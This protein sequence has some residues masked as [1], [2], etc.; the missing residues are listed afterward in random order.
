MITVVQ[1]RVG[2]GKSYEVTRRAIAHLLRGGV[3]ATNMV[4][5]PDRI[6]SIYRR[7]LRPWQ[8]LKLSADSDPR[9]IPRGDFRGSGRRRVMVILDEALNWFESSASAKDPRRET[10]GVWLRQS[11]KLGQ[12]VIFI[13]QEFARAAKWIRELAAIADDIR[14]FGQVRLFGMPIGKWLHANHLYAVSHADVRTKMLMGVDFHVIAPDVYDCYSTSELYDF[15]AS[16]SA[17][18]GTVPPPYRTPCRSL[19]LVPACWAFVRLF[20]EFLR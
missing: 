19:L 18:I 11:D 8:F 14:N 5:Y 20:R 4:L 13:A 1:G 10:W 9:K 12:D 2:T 17:Y 16:N 3:V 7:R 15:E 6:A